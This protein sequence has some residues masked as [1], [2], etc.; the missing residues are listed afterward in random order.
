MYQTKIYNLITVTVVLCF[1]VDKFELEAVSLG[2]LK[3]AVVSHDGDG[4]GEGWY[5]DKV[6]IRETDD[7]THEYIFPCNK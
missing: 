7:A 2:K 5:C 3:R 4:A 1:Q 6:V